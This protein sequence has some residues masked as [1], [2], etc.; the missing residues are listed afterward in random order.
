MN[1]INIDL[2]PSIIEYDSK[3]MRNAVFEGF[4]NFEKMYLKFINKSEN[5]VYANLYHDI[6]FREK[7]MSNKRFCSYCLIKKV[8]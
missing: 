1:L 8:Y 7:Y 4:D 6:N 3:E 5:M 2:N